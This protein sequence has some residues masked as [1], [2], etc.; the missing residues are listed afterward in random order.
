MDIVVDTCR[1]IHFYPFFKIILWILFS[2]LCNLSQAPQL[3]IGKNYIFLEVIY[4]ITNTAFGLQI[5]ASGIIL[6]YL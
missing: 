2:L 1:L 3:V 4:V 6:Y 5:N